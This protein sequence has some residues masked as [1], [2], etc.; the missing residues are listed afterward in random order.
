MN[1][2]IFNYLIVILILFGINN[3]LLINLKKTNKFGFIFIF[4]ILILAFSLLFNFKLGFIESF[5]QYILFIIGC[6]EFILIIY[7]LNNGYLN[8]I[9]YIILNLLSYIIILVLL[10]ILGYDVNL[11][12]IIF[13]IL[14][15]TSIISFK[16]SNNSDFKGKI[17]EYLILESILLMILGLTYPYVKTLHYTD[18]TPFTILTPTYE[19][20]LLVIFI[21]VL[22]VVGVLVNDYKK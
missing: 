9:T 20:I 8:K 10:F 22:I 14:S 11:L 12:I 18:F 19:L 1:S 16:L 7:S 6:I 2:L 4:P 17:S 15:F 21:V 3:G 5:L 13:V